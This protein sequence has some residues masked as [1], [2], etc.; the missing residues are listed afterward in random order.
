MIERVWLLLPILFFLNSCSTEPQEYKETTKI[1]SQK[2]LINDIPLYDTEE[3]LQ[4]IVEIP[5]GS[6]EKWEVNKKTGQLERDSIDGKPR[7]IDYLGYP[8]NYGFLPQTLLSKETGGDGDPLDAI[9]LGRQLPQGTIASCKVL[10]VLRLKD[11]GEQDDKL[12]LAEKNSHFASVN[13][14][15]ELNEKYP[16]LLTTI[17]SWFVHYKG[18]GQMV[19]EGFAPVEEAKSIILISENQFVSQESK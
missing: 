18:S 3:N 8:V 5:A 10:G 13:S 19:S 11:N 15:E 14:L 12:I 4:A 6:T 9:I 2:H 16:A 1:S 7:S 17:E